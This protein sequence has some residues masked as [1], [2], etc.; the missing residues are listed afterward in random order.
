MK[1]FAVLFC[2]F[3]LTA[4][5]QVLGELKGEGTIQASYANFDGSKNLRQGTCRVAMN[6]HQ[7]P[8]SFNFDFSV[9]ECS[10]LSP[11]N[12]TPLSYKIVDGQ[13][14]DSKG[15]QKGSILADGT[16]HFSETSYSVEKYT[17]ETYD[18]DCRRMYVEWKTLKLNNKFDYF[19]KRNEDG[20]WNVLR[21]TSEDRLAWTS[22]RSVPHCP[23]TMI[24]VKLGST[25]EIKAVVK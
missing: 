23:A 9:Y 5:A 3:T 13:L 15:Q 2:L 8:S 1:T 7:E 20:S 6:I 4:K 22:R 17:E 25:I 12:D 10:F 14:I 11:W 24:P 21:Q 19:F 16:I 18:L